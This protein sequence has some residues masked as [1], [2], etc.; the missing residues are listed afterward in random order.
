VT[1]AG[2]AIRSVGGDLITVD[3]RVPVAAPDIAAVAAPS[4]RVGG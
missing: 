4:T 2:A 1:I 3:E